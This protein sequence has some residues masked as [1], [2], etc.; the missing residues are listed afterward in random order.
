[1]VVTSYSQVRVL[2]LS[3]C[4]AP[5]AVDA[6]ADITP[7]LLPHMQP[8]LYN[9]DGKELGEFPKGD[10]YIRDLKNTKGGFH[11]KPIL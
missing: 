2:V 6:S 10:M 11:H 5:A 9:R 7:C 4:R 1:M 8:K 3:S